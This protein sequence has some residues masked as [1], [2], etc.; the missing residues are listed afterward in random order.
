[1]SKLSNRLISRIEIY[2]SP[3]DVDLPLHMQLRM[4]AD[5]IADDVPVTVS[6]ITA[7]K[8]P[9]DNNSLLTTVR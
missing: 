1:M 6:D 5:R 8:W 2:V 7:N 3:D 4:I 9:A